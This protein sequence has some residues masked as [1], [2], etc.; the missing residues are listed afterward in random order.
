MNASEPE[1]FAIFGNILVIFSLHIIFVQVKTLDL[2]NSMTS[3]RLK[4]AP[5]K[6]LVS[7][8]CVKCYKNYKM[9]TTP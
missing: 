6:I 8:F 2:T 9:K 5:C 7:H 1:S 3:N 4:A